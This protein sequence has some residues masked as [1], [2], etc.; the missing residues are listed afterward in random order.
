MFSL[1]TQPIQSKTQVS[2]KNRIR[3]NMAVEN[4]LR[5]HECMMSPTFAHDNIQHNVIQRNRGKDKQKI[6]KMGGSTVG[7]K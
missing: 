1:I 2:K 3:F 4:V 7:T 5:M 6:V